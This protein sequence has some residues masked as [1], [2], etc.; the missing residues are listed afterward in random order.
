EFARKQGLQIPDENPTGCGTSHEAPDITKIFMESRQRAQFI[1]QVKAVLGN[2]TTVENDRP[3]MAL[4]ERLHHNGET[5][6]HSGSR[7]YQS[8]GLLRISRIV[9]AIAL[10]PLHPEPV[11]GTRLPVKP[12]AHPPAGNVPYVYVK[13]NRSLA[14]RSQRVAPSQSVG[15]SESDEL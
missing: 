5:R 15:T 9:G 11:A 4:A 3:P 7:S 8:E 12:A 10:G 14:G 1:D 13:G 2:R 6:S